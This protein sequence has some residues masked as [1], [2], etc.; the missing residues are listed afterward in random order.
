MNNRG[1]KFGGNWTKKKLE[2]VSKYS[3]TYT[4]IMSKQPLD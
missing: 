3:R 2:C 1:H 4:T